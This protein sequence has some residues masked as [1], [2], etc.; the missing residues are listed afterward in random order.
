MRSYEEGLDMNTDILMG[1]SPAA[2]DWRAGSPAF[3][4]SRAR[5]DEKKFAEAL[6]AATK[7][8][9]DAGAT[10]DTSAISAGKESKKLREAC[11]GFEAIFLDMVFQEMRKTVPDDP[12]IGTSNAEKTWR[13]MLDTQLMK[14]I[15]SSGGVGIADM[16][17]DQLLSRATSDAVAAKGH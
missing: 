11:E 10:I 16:M 15:A 2:I 7:K 1:A 6:E 4:S 14:D 5:A 12:L 9:K 8:L 17:Y 3:Q 13:A